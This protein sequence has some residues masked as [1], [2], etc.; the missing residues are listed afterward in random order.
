MEHWLNGH[1]VLSYERGSTE[2]LAI[3]AQSKYVKEQKPG[4]R[5]GEAPTGRI[6]L[7]DH[8]DSTVSYRNLKIRE[9]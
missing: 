4:E 6:K 5:W 7:Q 1:K 8:N 2:L 9:L 3:V